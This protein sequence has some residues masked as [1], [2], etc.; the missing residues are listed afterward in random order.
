MKS[1]DA[2][3]KPVKFG[4]TLTSNAEGNTE[5]SMSKDKACV[6]TRRRVCNL[7]T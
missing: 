4:E 6:E 5:P 1:I 3:I 2:E 7:I